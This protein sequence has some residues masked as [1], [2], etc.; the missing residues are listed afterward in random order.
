M[1]LAKLQEFRRTFYSPDSA[2]ALP[3]LRARIEREEI[4]GGCRQGGRYYIDLDI[5]DRETKLALSLR[6]KREELS[7]DPTLA[8]LL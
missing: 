8:G 3:T 7:K 2:P 5:F 4:P 6:K 1:R